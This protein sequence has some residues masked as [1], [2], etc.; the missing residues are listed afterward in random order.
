MTTHGHRATISRNV[1]TRVRES[2]VN[3]PQSAQRHPIVFSIVVLIGAALLVDWALERHA[4]EMITYLGAVVLS[5]VIVDVSVAFLE[6][7][8][9]DFPVR[10]PRAEVMVAAVLYFAAA[11]VLA[12][13]FSSWFPVHGLW[14]RV[15][16]A[17]GMFLFGL[18][19]LLALFLFWRGFSLRDLGLRLW[20][21]AP[22]PLVMACCMGLVALTM[23]LRNAWVE[24]YHSIGGSIWA[25]VQ[26]GLLMAALPEE[27][28]RMVWQTRLGKLLNNAAAGWLVGSLLWASL[29]S[30]M[31]AQGESHL[32]ALFAVLGIVPYGLLLGYITHR[33]RSILPAILLHATKFVWL[34]NLG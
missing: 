17:A 18:Q 2:L 25:W 1:T 29:H 23:P 4:L 22:V 13:R 6:K 21:F 5:A 33:T 34:G 7:P 32:Q 24:N 10:A 15:L 19:I 27:F 16:F 14:L 11:A 9:I 30:F 26:V 31:Y 8:R 12:F 3:S 28:F 20:G